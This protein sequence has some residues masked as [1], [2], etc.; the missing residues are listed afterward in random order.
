MCIHVCVTVDHI[1]TFQRKKESKVERR[2]L[3]LILV[4]NEW[5][6]MCGRKEQPRLEGVLYTVC[7]CERER[8]Q[9]E[10]SGMTWFAPESTVP[11]G[12]W[13]ALFF[14]IFLAS[15]SLISDSCAHL[16]LVCY[17][18]EKVL[19]HVPI[20]ELAASTALVYFL[21]TTAGSESV[22]QQLFPSRLHY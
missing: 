7:V 6:P 13:V 15:H 17:F 12:S 1:Q 21:K 10:K 5:K 9:L 3:F 11:A 19:K 18:E 20:P 4:I 16:P 14:I 22:T 8:K 2:H